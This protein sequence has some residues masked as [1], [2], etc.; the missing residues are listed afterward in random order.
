MNKSK[1][2]KKIV[3][4]II[5]FIAIVIVVRFGLFVYHQKMAEQDMDMYDEA[6]EVISEKTSNDIFLIGQDIEFRKGI[7]YKKIEKISEETLKTEKKKSF[8]VIN[9]LDGTCPVAE[10]DFRFLKKKAD[11]DLA[12]NLIYLGTDKLEMIQ[13]MGFP[14]VFSVEGDMSYGYVLY[15]GERISYNGIWTKEEE[16]YLEKNKE[17]LGQSIVCFISRII[18]SNE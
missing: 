2:I 4:G 5:G 11:T 15:E 6:I 3:A 17:L 18:T 9:D 12:V 13:K 1:K 8:I 14:D 10:E 16:Q 7:S